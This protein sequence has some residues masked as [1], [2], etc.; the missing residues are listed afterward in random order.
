MRLFYTYITRAAVLHMRYTSSSL[1]VVQQI[2]CEDYTVIYTIHACLPPYQI[3]IARQL[4][5][6]QQTCLIHT[7]HNMFHLR[8][9]SGTST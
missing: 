2:A 7:L 6:D 1:L 4:L 5:F 9:L 3:F 8:P